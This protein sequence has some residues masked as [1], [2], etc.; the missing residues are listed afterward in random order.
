MSDGIPVGLFDPVSWRKSRWTIARAVMMNGR[1]KWKAKNRV[2]VALSTENPPQIHSTR[3]V[4]IYGIAE[5][6]LVMTVAP[7][8]D[9]CPHGKT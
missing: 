6:R 4:P 5:R 3:F 9:I 1:I 7:Q 2:R 8:N